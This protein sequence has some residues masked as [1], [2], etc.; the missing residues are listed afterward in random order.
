MISGSPVIFESTRDI[1]HALPETPGSD[2][3]QTVDGYLVV[4]GWPL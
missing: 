3:L 4:C 1:L 2:R